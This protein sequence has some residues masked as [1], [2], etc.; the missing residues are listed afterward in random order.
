MRSFL[1]VGLVTML[2]GAAHAEERAVA[3]TAQLVAALA[4]AN[5]GDVITLGPGTYPVSANLRCDRAGEAA[6]PITVR[7][8]VLGS[9]IIA[10][11][12]VEGFHVTAPH[13]RFEGLELHGTCADDADC[14]HGF[15]VTG[16]ADGVAIVGNR[17]VDFNAQIKG[18]GSPDGAGG[19]YTWPDDVLVEGNELYDTR[20][21]RTSNPVTKIDV[22]GG[23]R[24]IVRANYLH[25][26]AKAGGDTIS[27]AAFLKGNSR[28]GVIERNL[29]VCEQLHRGQIRLGLSLGGGGTSPD[30]ICE[31]ATCNPEHQHGILRNNLIAHCPADV[32]IYLNE[33]SDTKLYFNTLYDTT[34]IDVR[35][36]SSTATVRGNLVSGVIR[37]REGT[38]TRADNVDGV[39]DAMIEA[40]FTDPAGLDFTLV[41]GARIVEGAAG[42]PEVTDDFCGN[43]RT[44]RFDVGAVEYDGARPCDTRVPHP[45]SPTIGP[46][47]DG[48]LASDGGSGGDAGTGSGNDS[49]GC[50]DAGG[51]GDATGSAALAG[52]VFLMTIARSGR[53]KSPRGRRGRSGPPAR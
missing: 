24:W 44:G 12:A 39:G 52:L 32:G 1:A 43:P 20:P 49:G 37:D 16:R 38:S 42:V 15:H 13:W 29:V 30:S 33:A 51:P 11:S 53:P 5:P 28:D 40:W 17:V 2:A 46:D 45:G 26:F 47:P 41:D 36:A 3:T 8:A 22:V 4:V 21:R 25:D 23:R 18:N 27:Y 19:A 34:G 48:G 6:R 9:A 10:S 35:F 7:A 14:E 50:C 31:D